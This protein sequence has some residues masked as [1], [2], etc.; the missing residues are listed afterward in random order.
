MRRFF[1]GGF[2]GVE[3]DAGEEDCS[4][5]FLAGRF[6][7]VEVE[8]EGFGGSKGSSCSCSSGNEDD[9]SEVNDSGFA[10][11]AC[12]TSSDRS[13][14]RGS[15]VIGVSRTCCKSLKKS[16]NVPADSEIW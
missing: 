10:I 14:L 16:S 8:V 2:S 4:V 7:E 12:S 1:G 6:A 11:D 3:D 13:S 15:G 9:K 5:G